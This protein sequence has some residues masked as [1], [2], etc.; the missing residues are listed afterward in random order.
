M[1]TPKI[2]EVKIIFDENKPKT[3]YVLYKDSN[4]AIRLAYRSLSQYGN[5]IPSGM[6]M[7]A[8]IQRIV[9]Y[10]YQANKAMKAKH[11]PEVQFPELEWT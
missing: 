7:E 6:D 2:I 1:R 4:S 9:M 10:G 8:L 5:K 3:I 11:F